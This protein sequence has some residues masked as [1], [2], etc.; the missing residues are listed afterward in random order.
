MS[1]QSQGVPRSL[2][3]FNE[4]HEADRAID[5]L[6]KAGL[7]QGS[8]RGRHPRRPRKEPSLR[9]KEEAGDTRGLRSRRGCCRRSRHRRTRGAG[10]S[11]WRHS[12]DWPAICCGNAS[13]ESSQMPPGGAAIAGLSGAL[14]RLGYSGRTCQILRTANFSRAG[15]GDS[16]CGRTAAI[17]PALSWRSHGG[18]NHESVADNFSTNV[19]TCYETLLKQPQEKGV[20]IIEWQ[21]RRS[22][23]PNQEAAGALTGNDKLRGKERPTR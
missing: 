20:A 19:G 7:P 18:Y 15:R 21:D 16:P 23:R 11:G 10:S 14:I 3:F 5:D 9:T 12:R 13:H 2:A 17:A 8:D 1:C 22:E 6:V 4:R